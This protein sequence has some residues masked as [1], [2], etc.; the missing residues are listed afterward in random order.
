LNRGLYF[1]AA[2]QE[3]WEERNK[4]GNQFRALEE[5]EVMFLDSIREAQYEEERKRKQQDG[6]EL[7]NFREYVISF[8][9]VKF[10]LIGDICR[11]VAA[12]VAAPPPQVPVSSESITPKSTSAPTRQK[13]TATATKKDVRKSLKGVLVKKRPK[14]AA[15]SPT[16]IEKTSSA[17]N[18]GTNGEEA[19]TKG[20][21]S[22]LDEQHPTKKRK[23]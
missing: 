2:K 9:V 7:K 13:M 4:L 12:R 19:P 16:E 18:S 6:E 14:A 17:R 21:K 8:R 11:A 15:P 10:C 23:L 1:Q 3:E 22:D 20:L 5:D